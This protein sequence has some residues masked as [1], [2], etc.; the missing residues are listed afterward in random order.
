MFIFK[1]RRT[2]DMKRGNFESRLIL[3]NISL[4]LF[5][6]LL[7][8][9]AYLTRAVAAEKSSY[10]VAVVPQFPPSVIKRDWG[11]L[12][13][14]LSQ[15]TGL[16]LELKFYQSIP[17]FEEDFLKGRPDFVYLNPYHAVM[18][19]KSQG[20]I[21]LVRDGQTNLAGILVVNKNSS[22]TSV[23]DLDGKVLTFPSPNAFAASL[24]MRALL[25]NRYHITFTPQYVGTHSNVYRNVILEMS[26]AGGGV[27]K[28]LAKE[29]SELQQQ[30]RIIYET[31]GVAPHPLCAHPRI[32]AR[33][34]GALANAVLKLADDTDGAHILKTIEMALPVKADYRKDYGPLEKL[35]LEKF[36]VKNKD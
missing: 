7:F 36:E 13:T 6:V 33:V 22:F 19:R 26:A 32:P 9:P 21:P 31:P 8:D 23:K 10:T 2:E 28:T 12:M 16:K 18:A 3:F 30:L 29:S 15:D 1:A 20:Y 14:R 24:Y 35:G 5:I 27:N 17:E 11:P 34:R 25:I 4:F